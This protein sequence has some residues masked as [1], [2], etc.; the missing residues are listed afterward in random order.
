MIFDSNHKIEDATDESSDGVV[1]ID[2]DNEDERHDSA[3][4]IDC[5]SDDA[6]ALECVS[7]TLHQL[8]TDLR[9][10]FD[11]TGALAILH[12]S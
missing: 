1:I 12:D 9:H 4:V 2:D 7:E 6:F 8:K 3:S 10:E 11:V 5:S